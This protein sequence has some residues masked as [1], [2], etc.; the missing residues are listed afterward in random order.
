MARRALKVGMSEMPLMFE[1]QAS[2]AT[3][4][5]SA[6]RMIPENASLAM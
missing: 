2:W 1:T 5:T 4:S 6:V 3:S